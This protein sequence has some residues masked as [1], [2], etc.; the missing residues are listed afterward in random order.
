MNIEEYEK[1]AKGAYDR[2]VQTKIPPS[3]RPVYTGDLADDPM[4][5]EHPVLNWEDYA[6]HKGCQTQ[7]VDWDENINY[8]RMRNYRVERSREQLKEFGVGAILSLNEWNTR[9]IT[10]T[11]TPHWT[12]PSSGLRYSL[13][14]GNAKGP[15][16]YE[17]AEIGYH[18]RQMCPWL[19]KVKVAITGTGWSS[20]IIG[21]DAQKAQR[22]KFVK[23]IVDDLKSYGLE[24]EPLALDFSDPGIIQ[25]FEDAGIKVSL[26]GQELMFHARKIKNRDEVECLRVAAAIG[27]AQF[28]AFKDALKPGVRENE[29]VGLMHKVAYDLGA[30]VFSGIFCTSGEFS[31]PN[32]RETC[33]NRIIRPG[34]IVYADVYNTSYNGYKTCYYRTFCCGKPTQQMK[35]DYQRALDW[36]YAS[37]EVIKPG[38]TTRDVAEKWPASEDV[39][40]DILIKHEDQTAG[41]NWMHGIGLTLYELPMAWREASLENPLPLEKG[42][43]FAT[44][45]QLG[46]I[47]LGASRIEEMIH[48]TDTGVEI[49]TKWPIWEITECPL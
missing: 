49:L 34:D 32:P 2:F 25:G 38:M 14:A 48:I 22:D 19:D 15:I 40:S 4:S 36:L 5:F 12:T 7:A 11:W 47:G 16:V 20:I 18:T 26:A 29:L 46:R 42:M 35:D 3:D 28:Q 1:M 39:W 33:A 23:Q 30:E 37:I 13:F 10:G 43:T 21:R 9:Y 24:K 45:T 27:D 6:Y 41:S 31:W 17:N 8:E 44:E